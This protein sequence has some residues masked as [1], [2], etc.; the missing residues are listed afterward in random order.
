MSRGFKTSKARSAGWLRCGIVLLQTEMEMSS[1]RRV[2]PIIAIAAG[3][4][5][6]AFAADTP[7]VPVKVFV[8]AMFE[9]GK[10]TGDRA[11]E[12]QHWY[13]RY[14]MTS[15]PIAIH[16]ALN[17]V[18]CDKDGVCGAVLGMGKVASSSS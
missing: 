11:G 12:F 2:L 3:L 15:E 6:P 5:H 10:N 13:E 8:G 18:Y 17:P 1:M 16:G 9:I 7:P 14:W 4:S